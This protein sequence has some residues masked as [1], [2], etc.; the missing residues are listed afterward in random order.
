MPLDGTTFH[1]PEP[2]G[3]RRLRRLLV[4]MEA[5]PPEAV[6]I[7][8]FDCGTVACVYG[9]ALRDDA[10]RAEWE[11][12]LFVDGE[13]F[14]GIAQGEWDRVIAKTAYPDP[15]GA[16]AKREAIARIKALIAKYEAI[17]MAG[18]EAVS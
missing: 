18:A 7:R 10:L 9:W 4:V 1:R 13:R 2:D 5:A 8:K 3:L 6:D 11:P 15:I 12:T 16:P 17:H 14:F